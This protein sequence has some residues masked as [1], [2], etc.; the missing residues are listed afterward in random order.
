MVGDRGT[1]VADFLLYCINYCQSR[2]NFRKRIKETNLYMRKE[3]FRK[4]P[5]YVAPEIEIDRL[6]EE[7]GIMTTSP[8]EPGGD[9]DYDEGDF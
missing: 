8:G 3:L 4:K 1:I 2:S 5:E 6:E 9:L 7:S